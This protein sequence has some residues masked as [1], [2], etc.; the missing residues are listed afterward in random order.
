[1]NTTDGSVSTVVDRSFIESIPLN[2]RSLQPLITLTPGV[3]LTPATGNEQ[4]QFSVNGQRADANYFSVDGVGANF[5]AATPNGNFGQSFGGSLPALNISGGTNSLVSIDAIQEFRIETSSYAPEYGRSPGG[6]VA[7][8]T[9]SGTN[10][11]HG[12]VFDYF[13]NDA[14]DANDWFSDAFRLPKAAERQNDFGGVIVRRFLSPL[15]G[16]FG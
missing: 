4:G 12:D 11:L 13:R 16:W 3:V 8:A 14:L 15:Y 5:G 2:G 10:E 1:M 6:Q 7:I 9:R